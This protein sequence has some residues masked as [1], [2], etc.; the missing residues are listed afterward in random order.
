M[1]DDKETRD[2]HYQR[3]FNERFQINWPLALENASSIGTILMQDEA[4]ISNSKRHANKRKGIGLFSKRAEDV[5]LIEHARL[6]AVMLNHIVADYTKVNNGVDNT[7][8]V[9]AMS[10]F[11]K[12]V[13]EQLASEIRTIALRDGIDLE[14]VTNWRNIIVTIA[15]CALLTSEKAIGDDDD[16]PTTKEHHN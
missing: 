2:E 14:T 6:M 11:I 8:V 7:A 1:T 3:I 4:R 9:A 10:F 12:D 16:R 15:A 5:P 13:A